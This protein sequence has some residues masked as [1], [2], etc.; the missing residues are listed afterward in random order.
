MPDQPP[1]DSRDN[2]RPR[3]RFFPKNWNDGSLIYA[4]IILASITGIIVIGLSLYKSAQAQKHE[5]IEAEI[6][7]DW[8][9]NLIPTQ[10]D[11]IDALLQDVTSE[12]TLVIFENGTVV[13]VPEPSDDP[14]KSAIDILTQN[15]SPDSIF[16]VNRVDE[17]YAIRYKGPLF[18][19]ISGV[20]VAAELERIRKNWKQYLSPAELKKVE[21]SNQDPDTS[22]QIGLVARSFLARDL[23]DLKVTKILKAAS[24]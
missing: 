2:S 15:A 12:R 23:K 17:D 5:S 7:K 9:E 6:H 14:K 21:D 18:T 4:C 1:S 22:T 11:L 16:A 8:A 19:R 13:I 20:A 3:I 24:K 10:A